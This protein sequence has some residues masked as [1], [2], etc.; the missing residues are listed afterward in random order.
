[1]AK[2]DDIL[3][4]ADLII[5]K[6]AYKEVKPAHQPVDNDE[7]TKLASLLMQSDAE[8]FST[9]KV[10]KVASQEEQSLTEKVA[11]AM[12]IAEVVFNLDKFEKIAR[13]EKQAQDAGYSQEEID[14]F[15][16]E[17]ML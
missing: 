1:M 12:A 13:F 3:R 2:I 10:E 8:T 14:K 17:K 6:K 15:V 9:K 7:V 11:E 5:E 16:V 4:E